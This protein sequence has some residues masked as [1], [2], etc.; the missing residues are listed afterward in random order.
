ML[1]LL[2][3]SFTYFLQQISAKHIHLIESFTH[4]CRNTGIHLS[5]WLTSCWFG[6]F[7]KL[8]STVTDHPC[9]CTWSARPAEMRLFTVHTA[10]QRLSPDDIYSGL[11]TN[12]ICHSHTTQKFSPRIRF[13]IILFGRFDWNAE[14]IGDLNVEWNGKASS[15]ES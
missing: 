3:S 15:R 4:R 1:F 6:N 5:A 10:I 7:H 2:Q 12:A 13:D 9:V 11:C 8:L 14:R